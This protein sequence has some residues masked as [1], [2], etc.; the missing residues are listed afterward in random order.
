MIKISYS[1]SFNYHSHNHLSFENTSLVCQLFLL[2]GPKQSHFH[3]TFAQS[4]KNEYSRAGTINRPFPRFN[5]SNA[6]YLRRLSR[7]RFVAN[8]PLPPSTQLP[9]RKGIIPLVHGFI[10]SVRGSTRVVPSAWQIR[11]I[12]K[13]FT[14]STTSPLLLVSR[15][16]DA[17]SIPHFPI[18]I[19]HSL[20]FH[21]PL[22]VSLSLSLSLFLSRFDC[23]DANDGSGYCFKWH[24]VGSRFDVERIL[25]SRGISFFGHWI[26][27]SMEK[28]R[29][30]GDGNDSSRDW[31]G[32]VWDFGRILTVFSFSA[33][34]WA[35]FFCMLRKIGKNFLTRWLFRLFEIT[36]ARV[37]N[38]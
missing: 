1:K 27:S 9:L 2:T 8:P 38:M 29:R 31:W 16:P 36:K 22:R 3:P 7:N 34:R 21:A 26:L 28:G 37:C 24:V 5:G 10:V 17:I 20:P 12:W 30:E 15:I 25:R 33:F 13:S 6:A 19:F 11:T 35:F 4:L 18:A 23:V 32:L 14:N